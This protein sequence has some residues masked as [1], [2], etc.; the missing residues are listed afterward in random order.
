MISNTTAISASLARSRAAAPTAAAVFWTT[1]RVNLADQDA[2]LMVRRAAPELSVPANWLCSELGIVAFNLTNELYDIEGIAHVL[3]N[4]PKA[5]VERYAASRYYFHDDLNSRYRQT[6]GWTGPEII[7]QWAQ[8]TPGI[9]EKLALRQEFRLPIPHIYSFAVNGFLP[10]VSIAREDPLNE[11]EKA[12]IAFFA[13]SLFRLF[14]EQM[15]GTLIER[16]TAREREILQHLA[17]GLATPDIAR[18]LGLSDHT[19]TAHVRNLCAKL[20]TTKRLQAVALGFRF[21]LVDSFAPA[22]VRPSWQGRDTLER[23]Q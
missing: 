20:G 4:W 11:E 22:S 23:G 1:S 6:L 17:R 13:P 15:R 2:D 19:V 16:V 21:G 7:R 14:L 8:E 5:L 10:Y 12:I 3:T 9:A 18:E